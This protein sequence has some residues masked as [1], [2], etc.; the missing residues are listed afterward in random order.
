MTVLMMHMN[1]ALV[2]ST[3]VLGLTLTAG[4][5]AAQEN[6]SSLMRGDRLRV[7][8][9]SPDSARSRVDFRPYSDN[10]IERSATSR[11]GFEA[12]L[13]RV[14]GDTLVLSPFQSTTPIRRVSLS[15]VGQLE[16][17]RSKPD[18]RI[19]WG[20][21]YGTATGA[22]LGFGGREQEGDEFLAAMTAWGA[23]VGVVTGALARS[24]ARG[25]NALWGLMAGALVTGAVALVAG[26]DY[27]CGTSAAFVGLGAGIGSGIGALVPP[28]RSSWST[29][30][31]S[32]GR[33]AP[34]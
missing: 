27:Q 3:L 28:R 15:N 24:D 9:D 29:V 5:L 12:K 13:D 7:Y 2:L 11:L 21:S 34:E 32:T 8:A 19:L 4:D 17:Q 31:L 6:L 26:C 25:K 30:D 33:R 18:L 16:V 23:A 14:V 10:S 1:R 20:L 22:V